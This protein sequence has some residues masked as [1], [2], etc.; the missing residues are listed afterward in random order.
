MHFKDLMKHSNDQ[1]DTKNRQAASYSDELVFRKAKIYKC[2]GPGNDKLKL[3]VLPELADLPEEEFED[4]PEYPSFFKGQVIT[5]LSYETDGDNAEFV[6]VVCTPDLQV[7]YVLGKVNSFGEVGKDFLESYSHEDVE[8]Y[9]TQRRV[10]F[11]DFDYNH[12]SVINWVS[13]SQGGMLQAFNYVTGDFVILNTSGSVITIQQQQIFMRVGSPANPPTSPT[14]HSFVL[15]TP[16]NVH[17]KAP[18]I[19][20]DAQDLIL[21]KT[22]KVLGGVLGASPVIGTNGPSVTPV[23]HIHV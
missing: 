16:D 6:W 15:L 9:M 13:T 12:L 11:T 5:G 18:T 17:I 19:E 1:Y 23:S 22:G 7:G 21:G 14:A 3:Q 8:E 4:L 2:L 20:L 10:P